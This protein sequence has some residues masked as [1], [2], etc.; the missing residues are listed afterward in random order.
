[1]EPTARL[2]GSGRPAL[3]SPSR[4]LRVIINRPRQRYGSACDAAGRLVRCLQMDST[5][6]DRIMTALSQVEDPQLRQDLVSLDM[7]AGL[8]ASAD[9]TE[10]TLKLVS[11]GQLTGTAWKPQCAAPSLSCPAWAG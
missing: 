2:S 3:L 5:L 8:K 1:M 4:S 7:I 10:L 6:K 11:L 9:V